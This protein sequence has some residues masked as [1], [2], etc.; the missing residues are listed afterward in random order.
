MCSLLQWPRAL[1][2]EN[3]KSHYITPLPPLMATCL[4]RPLSCV[5]KATSFSGSLSLPPR[6]RKEGD[7][8]PGKEVVPRVPV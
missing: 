7:G 2:L 8:D 1:P 3:G 6:A 4:Q 5:T